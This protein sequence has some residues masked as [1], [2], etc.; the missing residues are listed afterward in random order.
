MPHKE[1]LLLNKGWKF[2]VGDNPEWANPAFNDQHWQTIDPTLDI[3]NSLPQLPKSGIAWFRLHLSLDPAV[4]EQQLALLIQQ[5]GASEVYLNG[6]LIHRFGTVSANPDEVEAYDPMWQ[7]VLAPFTDEARQVL[8]IR[9]ALEPNLSY[10]TMFESTNPALRIGINNL[11]TAIEKH[12]RYFGRL[13][14][15]WT[16]MVGASTLLIFLHTA[17]YVFYPQQKANLS[18][19]LFSFF[20]LAQNIIRIWTFINGHDIAS[21]FSLY[22][23]CFSLLLVADLF[24]LIAIYQL[25]NQKRDILFYVLLVMVGVSIFFIIPQYGWGWIA[26]GAL[27]EVLIKLNILRV[28]LRSAKRGK[29]V[30]RIIAWGAVVCLVFFVFFLSLGVFT[31]E[32]LIGVTPFR[33]VLYVISVLSIPIATSIYLGLDF[34]FINSTL[35]RKL[36]EVEELSEKTVAQEK[37]K[38]QILASQNETLERQVE[39]RTAALKES[40]EELSTTQ[41]QLIQKEKMASLG[42]LTAGIA[43]EIQNPLN[44]VNNFSGVSEELC[45]ELKEELK[46][47]NTTEALPLLDDLQQNLHKIHHH[48]HRAES[49]VKGMLQHSR[50]ATGEKQLTDINALADEFLRLSYHGLRAKDKSFNASLVTDFDAQLEKIEVVPQELGRVLLNLFNNAFYATQQKKIRLKGQFKPEVKL[51]TRQQD[52]KVEI[53]VRDNGSGIPAGIRSKI[54]Q[55]FFTTKPAGQG[56]GLGLSLSYDIITKGHGGDLLVDTKEDDFTEFTICLPVKH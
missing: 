15:F 11:N 9:Y 23:T 8:A 30:A 44:F 36:L 22:N 37:E 49:V 5:S 35:N 52:G 12:E 3:V 13:L 53:K 54:F 33:S 27:M 18:F 21:R 39:E 16:F 4:R 38:Q 55:P 40:L 7:P 19:A 1:D 29:R 20:F 43:H 34:A 46:A 24:L 48:G 42:E 56:T 25:S 10:T 47:G 26:G 41:N 6:H 32:F 17:F 45:A 31:H 14:I 50:S 28:A 2:Q 51:S